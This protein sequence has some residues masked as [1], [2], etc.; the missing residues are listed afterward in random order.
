MRGW[1]RGTKALVIWLGVLLVALGLNLLAAWG[2]DDCVEHA[3]S[4]Y[5]CAGS[6]LFDGVLSVTLPYFV[7]LWLVVAAV[8][9]L[10]WLNDRR[11]S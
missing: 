9:A 4:V 10:V 3:A 11:P 8:I 6:G 2:Y 1:R 5:E 7:G